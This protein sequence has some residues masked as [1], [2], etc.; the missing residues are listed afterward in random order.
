M[1]HVVAIPE[2]LASAATDLER[3]GST[4]S[5]ANAAAAAPTTAVEA[6]AEDEVSAA[7]ASLLSRHAQEFQT[8]SS[9]AAAFH[10]QF[11]QALT[12]AGNRYAAAE[13]AN[14]NPLLAA[15]NAPTEAL[16]GRP[17][18]GNGANGAA[19]T[20]QNGGDGGMLIGNGG[21][22]G[23]GTPGTATTAPGLAGPVEP[24]G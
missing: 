8:L 14:A 17:L 7:I 23:S 19:G 10:S 6:A 13:A 22:G 12:T 16:T 18:I 15:I 3:I 5:A 11:S 9:H 4:L 2:M 24:P 20:G 1:S 21:S